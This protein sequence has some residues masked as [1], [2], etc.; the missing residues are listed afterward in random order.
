MDQAL[1]FFNGIDAT[2]GA[3]L[4][5]PM[6][7]TEASPTDA[8]RGLDP[9]HTAELKARRERESQ[10][11]YG[12]IEEVDPTDLAQTGWGV[13]FPFGYEPAVREALAPLLDLR[14]A[15]AA[16]KNERYY[17]EYIGPDAYRPDETKTAFLRRH[18]AG[19]GPADPDKIPYYLLLVGGPREI[20]YRFQYQLDVQ[21]AVGRIAFDTPEEYAYYARSVVEAETGGLALARRAAFFGVANPG[22]SATTMSA[23]D[24]VAPLAEHA[25][26]DQPG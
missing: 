13:I 9:G 22:D 20:P 18:G 25:A 6:A 5:D 8:W 4:Q 3:Y 11:H 2:T 26:A 14:H 21:Y 19:P 12:V 23:A 1:L 10:G 16:A 15:Q 24:L 17:R 7:V